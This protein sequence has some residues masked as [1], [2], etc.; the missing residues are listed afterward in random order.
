MLN[1]MS[2]LRSCFVL[3]LGLLAS[4]YGMILSAHESRPAI[5]DIQFLMDNTVQVQIETNLEA[6]IAGIEAKHKN[7]DDSPNTQTYNRLRRLSSDNLQKQYAVFS[8]QY[9]DSITLL[10]DQQKVALIADLADI[11][12]VGELKISRLSVANFHADI[13]SS[14]KVAQLSYPAK[15]GNIAVKFRHQQEDA[16]QVH[17]LKDGQ[18]SPPFMLNSS[19]VPAEWYQVAWR[20]LVLGFEHI[21]PK[22]ID[23]ILFVLGLF[24]LSTRTK[25]LFTQVT[26]FTVAHTLTLALSIYGVIALSASIVEPLIALSIAYVGLE[27][28]LRPQNSPSR[29]LIVFAFGLLHG[30]GFSSVLRE[31]GLPQSEF[32]TALINFNIGVEVGQL[33]VI[34]LAF[35]VVSLTKLK[36]RQNYRN[37][38]VIPGSILISLVGLYWFIQRLG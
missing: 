8:R 10:F 14:G 30:L 24:L 9:A 15:Y 37:L 13:P 38:V 3:L 35:A 22:G 33:S 31:I 34:L 17:W 12:A 6:L 36:Q 20:Y 25:T 29:L 1:Y 4:F 7:T 11:P 27:N 26:A 21:I 28:V 5:A 16:K 23:H 32:L 19:V 18:L 2:F